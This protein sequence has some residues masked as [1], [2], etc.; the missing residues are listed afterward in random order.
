MRNATSRSR[1][2]PALLP[3]TSL[4]SLK[5]SRSTNRTAVSRDDSSPR[6]ADKP[7]L[8]DARL[9]RPV[10]PSSVACNVSVSSTSPLRSASVTWFA[11]VPIATTASAGTFRGDPRSSH[12]PSSWSCTWGS[13]THDQAHG[14]PT[15]A[16]SSAKRWTASAPAAPS[17]TTRTVAGSVAGMSAKPPVAPST[18]SNAPSLTTFTT[19]SPG[20]AAQIPAIA[21]QATFRISAA[22]V[23]PK[24]FEPI[25]AYTASRRPACSLAR[26]LCA[27]CRP[28]I[29]VRNMVGKAPASGPTAVP[30]V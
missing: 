16:S 19:R 15:A 11:R 24:R 25:D 27:R 6:T 13:S 8:N 22:S 28:T 20:V 30:P 5:S 1:S 26:R 7:A 3:N 10:R 2:S 14:V 18:R 29:T 12:A 17:L 21:V 9:A 4:T 23:R